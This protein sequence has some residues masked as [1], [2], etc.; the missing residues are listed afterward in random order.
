[1]NYQWKIIGLN[2]HNET[3]NGVPGTPVVKSVDWVKSCEDAEGARGSYMGYTLLPTP[4]EDS[5]FVNFGDV[6]EADVIKWLES[7]IS[8]SE[9]AIINNALANQ[10]MKRHVVKQ[11]PPWL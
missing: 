2:T 4:N 7:A 10:C 9:T 11:P 3:V 8:D 1:M 6:K 5:T